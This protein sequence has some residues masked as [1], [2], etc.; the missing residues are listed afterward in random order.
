MK[1]SILAVAAIAVA[2]TLSGCGGNTP[3]PVTPTSSPV[4]EAPTP[5]PT[6][7]ATAP[8]DEAFVAE[9]VALA[10]DGT[11]VAPDGTPVSCEAG[12]PTAFVT[13]EGIECEITDLNPQDY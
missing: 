9:E 7:E 8:V 12:T 6:Q 11:G 10:A 3:D 5:S 1:K 4:V 13:P 2:L